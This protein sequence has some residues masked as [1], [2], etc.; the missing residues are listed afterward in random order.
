M[1]NTRRMARC[2]RNG[3]RKQENQIFRKS[4]THQTSLPVW[5]RTGTLTVRGLLR[6]PLLLSVWVPCQMCVVCCIPDPCHTSETKTPADLSAS[7]G[8]TCQVQG[9]GYQGSDKYQNLNVSLASISQ[10]AG[11]Q[12][13]SLV[14]TITQITTLILEGRGHVQN[15][16]VWG[17]WEWKEKS[18]VHQDE[19]VVKLVRHEN[20]HHHTIQC[21]V[22]ISKPT[23]RTPLPSYDI[24]A[25]DSF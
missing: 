11:Q 21:R 3:S 4:K 7:C 13:N 5:L 10:F 23:T 20:T 14:G 9:Q 25:L 1:Y 15:C 2:A 19:M 17:T 22:E 16:F 12:A 6:I 24:V 18:P 8:G